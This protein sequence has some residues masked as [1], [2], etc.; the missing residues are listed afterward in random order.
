MI[1]YIALGVSALALGIATYSLYKST[2][3]EE[4]TADGFGKLQKDLHEGLD[5]LYPAI[6]EWEELKESGIQLDTETHTM[7]V[8]EKPVKVNYDGTVREIHEII[9][10]MTEQLEGDP[11]EE[12]KNYERERWEKEIKN[13]VVEPDEEYLDLRDPKNTTITVNTSYN[14]LMEESKM[15]SRDLFL[16]ND[17]EDLTALN[18]DPRGAIMADVMMTNSWDKD[19]TFWNEEIKQLLDMDVFSVEYLI[20]ISIIEV[21]HNMADIM[22]AEEPNFNYAPLVRGRI[23][24]AI[25][26]DVEDAGVGPTLIDQIANVMDHYEYK[27]GTPNSK[28]QYGFFGVSTE[29]DD[30]RV[31][32]TFKEQARLF[33]EQLVEELFYK[34]AF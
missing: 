11:S 14:E 19:G 3:L 16:A 26:Q 1:K 9:N 2:Q 23:L 15:A 5:T 20:D 21:I 17:D 8:E 30:P 4:A 7:S 18:E 6:D 27:L 24:D 31:F 10:D 28:D 32:G 22:D 34:G 29:Y 33:S 12:L 25:Y 13:R